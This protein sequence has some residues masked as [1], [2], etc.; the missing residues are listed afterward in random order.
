[1]QRANF[2]RRLASLWSVPR[3][4]HYY[5]RATMI[6]QW[7]IY[8]L[9]THA[10]ARVRSRTW[11]LKHANTCTHAKRV[12]YFRYRIC[13]CTFF[14]IFVSR[15][16]KTFDIIAHPQALQLR[17]IDLVHFEK[18]H[19]IYLLY[20]LYEVCEV[21]GLKCMHCSCNIDISKF[22][23][24][25]H[26]IIW[27]LQYLFRN[28]FNFNKVDYYFFSKEKTLKSLNPFKLLTRGFNELYYFRDH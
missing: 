7:N 12:R 10:R 17:A 15:R 28:L 16:S 11:T 22:I 26:E 27:L 1:M 21:D 14:Q 13:V 3:I 5:Y 24:W 25:H 2:V 19:A 8:W 20:F 23:S 6:R 18:Y 9:H 4:L